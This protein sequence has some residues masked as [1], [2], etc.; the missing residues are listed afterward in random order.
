MKSKVKAEVIIHD[1]Q[2]LEAVDFDVFKVVEELKKLVFGY[3]E[4][5][6]SKGQNE[7][8]STGYKL[9]VNVCLSNDEEVHR[10][11]KEFRGIDKATNVLSFA[12]IDGDLYDQLQCSNEGDL[13]EI[14][15][16]FETLEKEALLKNITIY[17]H[18]CH[19][20]VHGFLHLMGFDHQNDEDA[21]V[22]EG[23][24]V[25]ILDAFSIDNPY[26]D[27]EVK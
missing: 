23:L 26:G 24:E 11:N 8:L 25:E 1:N 12:E 20:L 27:E 7:I 22:M 21:E 4:K 14:V 2:W 19:L 3:V 13:G 18:F 16:A 5:V 10:L 9:N 15:L 17:A 6:Y